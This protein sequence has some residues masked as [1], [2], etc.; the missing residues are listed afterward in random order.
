MAITYTAN[1]G[2]LSTDASPLSDNIAASFGSNVTAGSLV[3]AAISWDVG[4]SN[5]RTLLDVSDGTSWTVLGTTMDTTNHQGVALAYRQNHPGGATTVTATFST[6]TDYK[7]IVLAEYAGVATTGAY[8]TGSYHGQ[9][10]TNTTAA[11]NVTPG[12]AVTPTAAGAIVIGAAMDTANASNTQTAGTG[13]TKR[14][15]AGLCA[16]EDQIQT[17]A[18]AVTATWTF[19]T[20]GRYAANEA[21]FLS[22]GAAAGYPYELLTPTPRYV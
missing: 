22:D 4:P 21:V 19:G 3:V 7:R 20:A 13:F 16:I 11:N 5:N 18:A 9:A 17:S 15:S 6:L 14:L 1:S 12:T 8:D 2:S 10:T